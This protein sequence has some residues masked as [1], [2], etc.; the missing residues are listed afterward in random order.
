MRQMVQSVLLL[1]ALSPAAWVG[2]HAQQTQTEAGRP[3]FNITAYGA[4]RDGSAPATEAF[5]HAIAAAKAA[6]GG[7]VYVPA[8]HYTSGP[9]ELI[10]HL[11]L[12]FG[13]GAIVVFPAQTL[14]LTKGR[15]QGIETLTPVPLIGGHDLEDVQVVGAGTLVSSNADWMNLHGRI[16]PNGN[17][18]GS[19]N[20]DN[21]E[22]LL[23]DLEAHKPIS[24]AQ[25]TAAAEELRPSF[26]RFMNSKDILVDGLHFEGSPMWTVHLLY[27]QNAVVQ[28]VVIET[29]PGVHTDGI[30]VDSS[31][32]VHLT[33][34]YID[35]GDDGIVIKSGKDADGLRVNRATEDVTITGCTVHHAHGAVT[36]GSET[37][38]SVRNIVASN[39]TA[40]DTQA[41][42]RIKSRRGRGG[43]VSNLRFSNWAMRNVGT[44]IE[45][46][47]FYMMEGETRESRVA[48]PKSATTPAFENI[49][50]NGVTI[51]GAKKLIDVDGL[52]ESPIDGLRI[53]D[54]IGTGTVGAHLVHASGLEL[55]NV[56][57]NV[58]KGPAFLVNDCPDAEFDHVASRRLPKD[59]PVIRIEQSE[60]SIVRDS[61]TYPNVGDG[62]LISVGSQK[63]ASVSTEGLFANPGKAIVYDDARPK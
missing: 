57:M 53:S 16:Q 32:F 59:E 8:G 15:Q 56:Q 47:N 20:G 5:A 25:Y 18:L 48:M 29:S 14:P 42:I 60:G 3:V 28:N 30:V 4:K 41:G 54:V 22:K 13:P 58:D 12:E 24:E 62:I 49:A 21:W 31:R 55:H 40:V 63:P 2:A 23:L 1:T 9:I 51:D 26:L 11:R 6:G 38:G 61:R 7:T 27:T 35:T 33:D 52:P 44:A 19:A 34:D 10:S 17:S 46:T 39:M 37:S 43:I 45:V 36:I 50:I